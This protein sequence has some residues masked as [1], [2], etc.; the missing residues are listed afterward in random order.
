VTQ[1]EYYD[2]IAKVGESLGIPVIKQY[3]ISQISENTP[4][5]IADN[6]HPTQLGAKQS[7]YAIWSQMRQYFPNQK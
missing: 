1:K 3:A 7:A 5:Y 2:E 6:I 4:Q